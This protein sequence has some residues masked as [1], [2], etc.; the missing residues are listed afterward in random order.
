LYLQVD[1]PDVNQYCEN[2]S[3][4]GVNIWLNYYTKKTIWNEPMMT[5]FPQNRYNCSC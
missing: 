3:A 4:L 5:E 2:I 1:K